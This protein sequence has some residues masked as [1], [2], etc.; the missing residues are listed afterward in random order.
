MKSANKENS[1]ET[2]RS[3][4]GKVGV[5]FSALAT[6]VFVCA[7]GYGYFE[8]SKVNISLAKMIDDSKQ[9]NESDIGGTAKI[10]S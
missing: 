8:L 7:F 3:S 4:W 6:I 9:R 5:F 1:Q 2:R 10:R